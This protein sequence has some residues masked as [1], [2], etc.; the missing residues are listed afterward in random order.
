M[1]Q[2]RYLDHYKLLDVSEDARQAEIRV[3][4][5][6]AIKNLPQ[7]RIDR[8]I[9]GLAGRTAERYQAAYD[10]LSDVERRK[11]YD[12]YLEQGRRMLVSILH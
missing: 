6:R 4:F 2:L 8:F 5:A 11:K 9:A 7:G 3:A 12:R 1:L 10:E